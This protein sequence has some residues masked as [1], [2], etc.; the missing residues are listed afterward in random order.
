MFE[1]SSGAMTRI[2]RNATERGKKLVIVLIKN[3]NTERLKN[4]IPNILVVLMC[5][6]RHSMQIQI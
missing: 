3:P 2:T 1:P 6:I 5:S 4:E